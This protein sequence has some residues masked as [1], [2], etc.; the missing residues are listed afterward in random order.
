M[1]NTPGWHSACSESGCIDSKISPE[2]L[3][4]VFE[5]QTRE[6]ANG[7]PRGFG[8]HATLQILEH[9]FANNI[10]LCRLLSHTSRKLQPCD[11]AV[12]APLKVAYR[13]N[14]ERMER[15]GINAI[16][17][18]HFTALYSPA[19]ELSFTR[20]NALAGWSKCV[21]LIKETFTRDTSKG[22][23]QLG[24]LGVGTYNEIMLIHDEGGMTMQAR[25]IPSFARSGRPRA[26]LM[27]YERSLD[28]FGDLP[29]VITETGTL[30][31][32]REFGRTQGAEFAANVLRTTISCP[33][34]LNLTVIDLPGLISAT[35]AEQG[36]DDTT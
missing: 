19:R 23:A 9:C 27:A 22:F 16:G 10:L 30:M 29:H 36:E 26:K 34:R 1:H 21:D 3:A 8:T 5:L 13:D 12:F 4:R 14:V 11:I 35:N 18:Q 2:W 20:R 15:V 28:D 17:K 31:G 33:T 7:K 25:I 24:V 32:L 6:R